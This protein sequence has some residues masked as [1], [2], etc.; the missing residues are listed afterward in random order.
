[1]TFTTLEACTSG[2]GLAA[3]VFGAR[4]RST[5]F[6]RDLD[7]SLVAG[8]ITAAGLLAATL[9]LFTLRVPA[10][11]RGSFEEAITTIKVGAD[12]FWRAALAL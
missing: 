11:H 7:E 6:F 12:S 9:R 1:V 4:G 2:F 8:E 5:G 10:G 3:L